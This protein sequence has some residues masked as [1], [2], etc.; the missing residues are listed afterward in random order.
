MTRCIVWL[1]VLLTGLPFGAVRAE[2]AAVDDVA[3]SPWP[4][5]ALAGGETTVFDRSHGAFGRALRNLERGRWLSMRAGKRLFET[6]WQ[7]PDTTEGSSSLSGLGPR[8]NT[9]SCSGCHFRDGRGAPPAA[10]MASPEPAPPVV[11]LRRVDNGEPDP[12]YGAQLNDHGAG[13]PAEGRVTIEE[14]ETLWRA[15]NGR[16]HRLRRP[17]ARLTALAL[18]PMHS[19]TRVDLRVP[20]TLVGLGLLEAV[21]VDQLEALADP[22]DRDGDGISGRLRR[23]AD[24]TIGRFGWTAGQSRL[25]AQVANAFHE[26]LGVTSDLRPDANCPPDDTVCRRLAGDAIELTSTQLQRV[27]LYTRLLA[28]PARRGWDEPAVLEGRDVFLRVGCGDC[29]VPSLRTASRDA[30][31]AAQTHRE[32]LPELADQTIWPYTDLLLHDLGPEMADDGVEP[33]VEPGE[34][35]TAPLWGLGLHERVNGHLNL[36][37]DGRART[38]EDAILWHGGEAAGSRDRFTEL[39]TREHEAL[40]RFL[41]SL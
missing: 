9:V 20:P 1:I 40:L 37:H 32:I 30:S 38:V 6:P 10:I 36:L 25:E 17:R 7:V 34:W 4:G 39:S 13:V 23:L 15:V 19:H 29:H 11:R 2:D 27:A 24:G 22:D 31:S 16:E 3:P 41:E 18:G 21:P 28:P 14:V 33:G 5:E 35:R 8:F 12:R 26:D